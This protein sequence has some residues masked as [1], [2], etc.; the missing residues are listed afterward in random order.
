MLEEDYIGFIGKRETSGKIEWYAILGNCIS[1][2]PSQ[3]KWKKSEIIINWEI[4]FGEGEPPLP[5]DWIQC[6]RQYLKL[7]EQTAYHQHRDKISYGFY[8]TVGI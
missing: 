8:F 6:F 4:M 5:F 2:K 7:E 3:Q 1:V